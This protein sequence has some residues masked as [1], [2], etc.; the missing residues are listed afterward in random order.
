MSN[1]GKNF[2]KRKSLCKEVQFVI[3]INNSEYL[4]TTQMFSISEKCS[5]NYGQSDGISDN[6]KT[7]NN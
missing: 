1:V 7:Y 3:I 5:A 6:I 2:D 4:G